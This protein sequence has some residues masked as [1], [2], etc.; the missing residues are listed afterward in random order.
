MRKFGVS[1]VVSNE[2]ALGSVMAIMKIAGADDIGYELLPD[3]KVSVK[4][5]LALEGPKRRRRTTITGAARE[6][7]ASVPVGERFGTA[8]VLDA[9]RARGH[10]NI[11]NINMMPWIESGEVE[12]VAMG[13]YVKKGGR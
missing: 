2:A 13:R 12:R 10:R 11:A 4:P 8:D 3:D 6:F 7:V 1:C 9:I 5:V